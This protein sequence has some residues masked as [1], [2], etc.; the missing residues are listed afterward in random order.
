MNIR[1]LHSW[2]IT[3]KEAANV[4]RD[5][6][7]R[8][9]ARTP[10]ANWDLIAGA[11]VSYNRYSRTV[12]AGVV[13]M[14]RSDWTVVEQQ[15]AVVETAFPY[16]PGFL[17]FREAP[18]LLEAFARLNAEP[19]VVLFDGQGLAHPRRFGLACHVGL[20]LDR[21]CLGCAKS[22]LIGTHRDPR[23][24]R[25]SLASLKDK[26]EVIGSVVRTRDGIK[27]LYVS[28][29]HKIDLP[30]AVKVVLEASRSYRLPEPARLAHQFVNDLRR[31]G[32]C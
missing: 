7:G 9:E 4:Q 8:V 29:G 6:A 26:G 31:R 22:R 18:P 12:Y 16:I 3:P 10:L 30:S 25:G 15:G 27:P 21:P 23:A 17:S 32:A 14:R 11:D 20:W 24:K 19:D 13:V 2:D 1:P 5:L 28:V